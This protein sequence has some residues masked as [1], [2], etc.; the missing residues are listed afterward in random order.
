MTAPLLHVS[1]LNAWYGQAHVLRGVDL[2][3]GA[4]ETVALLGRNG[5]GRSTICQA[6]MG[7]VRATG[8]VRLDGE[9]LLGRPPHAVARAGIGLVP[10]N[11]DVFPGLTTRQNLLLGVKPGQRDGQGGWTLSRMMD[12]FPNLATRAEVDAAALS[13]GEQQ[14]LSICRTLMGGPRLIMIDEPTEGLSPQMTATVRDLIR[15][16]SAGGTAVLLV[17]QKLTIAMDVADRVLVIGRGQVQFSGT[18]AALE[19][20]ADIREAWLE[21]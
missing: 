20:R 13:G 11:R 14:M 17:E 10:E 15:E 6:I 8:H 3:I 21:V 19:D 5:A 4:G 2:E 18:P 1:D 7:H 16:I 12:L 9:E